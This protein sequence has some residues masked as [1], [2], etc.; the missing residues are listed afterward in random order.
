[1]TPADLGAA[2]AL[3]PER[4]LAASL[5]GGVAIALIWLVCRRVRLS[6]GL[7]TGLW[8]LASLKLVSALVVWP[9]IPL[10]LLPAPTSA[11]ADLPPALPAAT[12]MALNGVRTADLSVQSPSLHATVP[13]PPVL[14]LGGEPFGVAAVLTSLWFAGVLGCLAH[15]AVSIGRVRRRV[16]RAVPAPPALMDVTI[17]SS[18]KMFL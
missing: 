11:P 9:S 10:P 4:L 13:T 12:T 18:R 15:M 1:M 3:I 5:Q 16:A 7:R 2:A 6:P 17:P 8:W 14:P